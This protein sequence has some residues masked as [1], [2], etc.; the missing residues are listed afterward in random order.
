MI[1][2]GSTRTSSAGR[3]LRWLSHGSVLR[4]HP[5]YYALVICHNPP[6]LQ[7]G[8]WL[9]KEAT[10]Y[11]TLTNQYGTGNLSAENWREKWTES[12]AREGSA[13]SESIYSDWWYSAANSCDK[14]IAHT[15][16][17]VV[18]LSIW[19]SCGAFLG[20]CVGADCSRSLPPFCAFHTL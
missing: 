16:R 8:K 1:V 19:R 2:E 5:F 3:C 15:T 18:A 17:V 6:Y 10:K 14:F 13:N 20:L 9:F 7:R 12:N 11:P 4:P